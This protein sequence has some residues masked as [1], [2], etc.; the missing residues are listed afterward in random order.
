M[1]R[2]DRSR[3]AS[4]VILAVVLLQAVPGIATAQMA[5]PSV[6]VYSLS[7]I[8]D[9][10][11]TSGTPYFTLKTLS[12]G[13]GQST[14][15]H[16]LHSSGATIPFTPQDSFYGTMKKSRTV[17]IGGS[18]YQAYSVSLGGSA[19]EF[20]VTGG[21]LPNATFASLNERGSTL[22]PNGDGTYSYTTGD[23]TVM[24]IDSRLACEICYYGYVVT[25][26]RYPDGRVLKMNYYVD[27]ATGTTPGLRSVTRNDGWQ[28]KYNRVSG[29]LTGVTA[30]N[31]AYDYC[32]P[33]ADTCTLTRAWPTVTYARQA[34]NGNVINMVMTVTDAAGRATRYTHD[35]AGRVVRV[36][37]PSSASAD[38]L[39]YTYCDNAC[40]V[41]GQTG[42]TTFPNMVT[43]VMRD[44]YQWT[45]NYSPGSGFSYSSYGSSNPVGGGKSATM[46]AT[47]A[48]YT[49]FVGPVFGAGDERVSATF[50]VT[51]Y[52]GRVQTLSERS[53]PVSTYYYDT[54]GNVT[55]VVTAPKT[56]FS[57]P[58]HTITAN[59]GSTCTNRFTCNKPNYVIDA[60]N[61]RTDYTYDPAHGGVLTITKPADAFGVRP[62]VRYTYTQ[63][64]AWIKGPS[65]SYVQSGPI[66]VR[67][68]E[69]YCRTGA[70]SASDACSIAGD[71][72]VIEFEYGP[73]SGPNNL[74]PRGQAI[75]ADGTTLRTCYGYDALGNKISETR[76]RAGLSACP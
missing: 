61:A 65:G 59:Y 73:N 75:T 11:L 57:D 70:T 20:Y 32:D 28:I 25:Q 64:N 54:R 39:I 5:P 41:V 19:E 68:H 43:R 16:T 60:R 74:F 38:N 23:G 72:V 29:T 66:W 2:L 53:G 55:S 34:P 36:K 49:P 33:M 24:T 71:E 58:T 30:I 37:W 35:S 1:M 12:V 22:A 18:P 44:G 6:P 14:I 21:T 51:S 27:P 63:R 15:E 76:P 56:G 7:D 13:A 62:K 67:T 17:W 26:V 10:N 45:Y 69:K 52:S 9:V 48:P 50:D 31:N 3:A 8:N 40:F 47:F 4:R 46:P 42:S